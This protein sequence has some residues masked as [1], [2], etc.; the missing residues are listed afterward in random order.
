MENKKNDR[1]KENCFNEKKKTTEE[2]TVV[3]Q[4]YEQFQTLYDTLDSEFVSAIKLAKEKDDI[5][6][7]VTGNVLKR[8][9]EEAF[10]DA[11]KLQETIVLLKEI[12]Q[13]VQ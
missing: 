9:S 12:R 7:V 5:T 10:E 4:K 1:E 6:L 11:R 2:I 13:K 8:K 3:T